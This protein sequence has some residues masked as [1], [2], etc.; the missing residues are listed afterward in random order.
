MGPVTAAPGKH[1]GARAAERPEP[2]AR[3]RGPRRGVLL[4]VAL[5]TTLCLVAWGYLVWAAIDFG[6]KGR[7]GDSSAWTYLGLACVGAIACLFIGLLLAVRVLKILRVASGDVPA[8][9]P[10]GGRRAKR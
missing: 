6:R 8:P 10:P 5:G 7:G 4:A 2:V 3:V 9:P 1:A